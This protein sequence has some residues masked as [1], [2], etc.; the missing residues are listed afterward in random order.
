MLFERSAIVKYPSH[1]VDVELDQMTNK[2][3]F[4]TSL[5]DG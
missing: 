1:D 3:N 4:S 2:I 5:L